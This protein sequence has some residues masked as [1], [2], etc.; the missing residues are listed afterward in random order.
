MYH[1]LI[2]VLAWKLSA[3]VCARIRGVVMAGPRGVSLWAR[4]IGGRGE[5]ERMRTLRLLM[6]LILKR[7]DMIQFFFY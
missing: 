7:G 6:L 2:V 1:F 3:V 5:V 4:G